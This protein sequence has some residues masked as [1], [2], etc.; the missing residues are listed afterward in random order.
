MEKYL[1]LS[2]ILVF[3]ALLGVGFTGY[4]VINAQTNNNTNN[5]NSTNIDESK[6]S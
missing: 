4:G 2:T 1:Q 6:I 5:N 3:V